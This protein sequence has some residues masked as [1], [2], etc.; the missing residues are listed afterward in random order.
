M[1]WLWWDWVKFYSWRC[2]AS[3]SSEP[4]LCI[5]WLYRYLYQESLHYCTDRDI[6]RLKLKMENKIDITIPRE[7]GILKPSS[8]RLDM[9][10]QSV[11]FRDGDPNRPFTPSQLKPQEVERVVAARIIER[12]WLSYRDRKMYSLLK[13]A[14]CAAEQ[15]LSYEIL[16]KVSP[17]EAQLLKDKG[18]PVKVRFR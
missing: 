14:T 1:H 16:R 18:M 11:T 10:R 9:G 6:Q 5:T 2:R 4:V 8:N 15:S 7:G 17:K 12:A 3:K 13:H